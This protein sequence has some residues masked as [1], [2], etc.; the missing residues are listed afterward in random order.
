MVSSVSLEY[1]STTFLSFV[2]KPLTDLTNKR[3]PERIPFHHRERE[4]F[5]ELRSY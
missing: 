5:N 3:V 4:A 2:A 1:K